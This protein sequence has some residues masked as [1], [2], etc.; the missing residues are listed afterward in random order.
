MQIDKFVPYIYDKNTEIKAL[1]SAEKK[2]FQQVFEA[3]IQTDFKNTFIATADLAGIERFELMLG[4]QADPTTEDIEFR[5]QRL[6]NRLNSNPLYTERF[7]QGKLDEIIGKDIWYYEINYNNYTLD[8]Y[9]T[10]PGKQWLNELRVFLTKIMP[11]N[12]V[13]TIHI[14]N[15]TW[16]AVFDNIDT[17]QDIYDLNITWQE[18]MEGEWIE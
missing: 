13:W 7:L 6:W 11:C 14:Y 10:R 12:I 1:I 2:E 18:V 15:L 4:I 17:W 5:R 16:Q 8:I 9:I 3:K